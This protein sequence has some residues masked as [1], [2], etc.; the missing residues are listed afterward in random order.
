MRGATDVNGDGNADILLHDA[1][2]NK[3]VV[4]YMSGATRTTY[5]SMTSPTGSVLV[6]L[7]DFDGNKKGD[8][9]WVHPTS[10]QIWL[11]LSAGASFA[12]SLLPYTY[13]PAISDA[14]DLDVTP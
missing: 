8:I 6:A 10:G 13:A 4:W 3:L 9:G 11:S 2:A 1:V 14:M 7:G 12:T 5:S